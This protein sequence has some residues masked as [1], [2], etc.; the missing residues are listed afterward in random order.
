MCGYLTPSYARMASQKS[1]AAPVGNKLKD[2]AGDPLRYLETY[3][4][5]D[6]TERIE[7]RPHLIATRLSSSLC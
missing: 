7:M 2:A 4:D 1:V 5:S 3:P 6:V